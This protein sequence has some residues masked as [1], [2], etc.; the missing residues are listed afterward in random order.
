[1]TLEALVEYL[2]RERTIDPARFLALKSIVGNAIKSSPSF[3]MKER[4][5]DDFRDLLSETIQRF[6][7]RAVA[8]GEPIRKPEQYLRRLIKSVIDASDVD[9]FNREYLYLRKRV[10][11]RLEELAQK[12]LAAIDRRG[13]CAKDAARLSRPASRASAEEAKRA[14]AETPFAPPVCFERFDAQARE[15]LDALIVAALDVADGALYR[16]ELIDD[17]ADR[18]GVVVYRPERYGHDDPENGVEI[19]L[20]ADQAS[21]YECHAVARSIERAISSALAERDALAK[22]GD[23]LLALWYYRV[24]AGYT[25]SSIAERLGYASPANV[26]YYLKKHRVEEKYYAALRDAARDCEDAERAL[27]HAKLLFARRLEEL[28]EIHLEGQYEK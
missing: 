3:Y 18:V 7:R 17:I 16:N 26:D 23:R 10:V 20:V 12:G 28:F 6:Y 2:R 21:P 27:N 15:R 5:E 25:L 1:M 11:K 9:L 22:G 4:E 14:V 13:Y 19:P 24:S 8:E